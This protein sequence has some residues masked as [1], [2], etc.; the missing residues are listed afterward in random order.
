VT[1]I[2]S[3]G[4]GSISL[5][6]PFTRRNGSALV[7]HPNGSFTGDAP[8]PA[9]LLWTATA[10]SPELLDH[11][12][13]L[14][15][16]AAPRIVPLADDR[17]PL[18][19]AAASVASNY[20]LALFFMAVDLYRRAGLDDHDAREVVRRFVHESVDRGMEGGA[21]GERLTGPISRGDIDVVARQIVAITE[22]AP[23]YRRAFTALGA[24]TA[25]MA[26]KDD[27]GWRELFG[28]DAS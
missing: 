25:M 7:L 2:H 20:S 28:D 24:M 14:L 8:V 21:L 6:A 27:A 22:A 26:G 13:R 5:L 10:S 1:A 3:S 19:H 9:G 17:R 12:A 23:D 11:A 18:Y 15:A 4:A 16:P